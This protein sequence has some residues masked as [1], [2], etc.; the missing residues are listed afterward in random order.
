MVTFE[1]SNNKLYKELFES[2]KKVLKKILRSIPKSILTDT[3]LEMKII[4]KDWEDDKL[5]IKK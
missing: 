4:K 2:Y 1:E 3:L 5:V